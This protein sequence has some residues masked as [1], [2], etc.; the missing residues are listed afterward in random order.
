MELVAAVFRTGARLGGPTAEK[1]VKT[2][3]QR[4]R[5]AAYGPGTAL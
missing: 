1:P 3:P 4:W 5:V 2:R